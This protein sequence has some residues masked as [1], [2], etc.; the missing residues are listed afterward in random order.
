MAT[1]LTKRFIILIGGPGLFKKAAI[2]IMIK[3]GQI[4]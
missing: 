2:K 4:I 3:L 1:V